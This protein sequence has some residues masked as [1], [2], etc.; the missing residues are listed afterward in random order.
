MCLD[1]GNSCDVIHKAV[2]WFAAWVMLR[3][4]E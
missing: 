4:I 2:V 1:V 3:P